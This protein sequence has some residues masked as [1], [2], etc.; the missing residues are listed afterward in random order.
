MALKIEK[1]SRVFV[2]K[3]KEYPDLDPHM[4]ADKILTLMSNDNPELVNAK[5][6]GPEIK[7]DRAVY[8]I[9]H[10]AGTKG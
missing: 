6:S 10:V 9:S 1:L 8:Q 3:G 2:Y 7:N 4:A 5:I